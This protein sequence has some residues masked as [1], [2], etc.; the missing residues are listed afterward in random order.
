M[1]KLSFLTSFIALV[2]SVK[3]FISQ[4]RDRKRR[5]AT[6]I[7]AW[8]D[9]QEQ[10]LATLPK[11]GDILLAQATIRNSSSLP[12][13]NVV[14]SSGACMGA[15][16]P[17]YYGDDACTVIGTLPPGTYTTYIP[18]MGLGMGV[19]PE[20]AV[21]FTDSEGISWQRDATGK[22][23]EISDPYSVMELSLPVSVRGKLSPR[24]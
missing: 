23:K 14:L 9:N 12:V 19:M 6:Q 21:A 3:N 22:L 24:D 17:I 8:L 10:D 20:A 2:I 18:Y 7:A 11:R 13:Y 15:G 1:D 4:S 5:H 16:S